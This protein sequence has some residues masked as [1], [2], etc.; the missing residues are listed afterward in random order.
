[1]TNSQELRNL[2]HPLMRKY[3]YLENS[4]HSPAMK[5]TRKYSSMNNK[6]CELDHISIAVLKR[7]LPTMLGAITEIV[8]LL[9]SMDS[10]AQDWKIAVVK[11]LL[12]KPGLDLTKRN[13][14]PVSNLSF[15]SKLV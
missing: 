5:S 3:H 10:F 1:M 11:P 9:L 13:C 8:N 2:N 7:I 15:L 6:T 4:Y 14:R 12:K